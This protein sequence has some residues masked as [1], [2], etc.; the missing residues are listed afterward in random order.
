MVKTPRIMTSR[1]LNMYCRNVYRFASIKN[2]SFEYI[3]VIKPI[4]YIEITFSI[5]TSENKNRENET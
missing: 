3:T 2:I 4:N 1:K 5:T